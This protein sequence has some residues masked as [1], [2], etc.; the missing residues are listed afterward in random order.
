MNPES[1]DPNVPVQ[2][3]S[4]LAS[5]AGSSSSL[6]SLSQSIRQKRIRECRNF[7][8]IIGLIIAGMNF[9]RLMSAKEE[10]DQV[11]QQEIVKGQQQRMVVDQNALNLQRARIMTFVQ[12]IYGGMAGL[13]VLYILLGLVVQKFPVP[14]TIFSLVLYIGS[15]AILG[16]L[17]PVW[18]LQAIIFKIIIIA[19]FI[20]AIQAAISY[21]REMDNSSG[22]VEAFPA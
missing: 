7:L 2:T 8:I 17:D 11:I 5:L 20:K 18:L 1:M 14:I 9:F 4:G 13:G 3:P 6:G 19:A 21:Q 22:Q 10:V 12:I 15:N 16:F